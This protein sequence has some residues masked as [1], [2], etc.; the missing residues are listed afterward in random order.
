MGVYHF[1]FLFNFLISIHCCQRKVYKNSQN[2]M[3]LF[4]PHISTISENCSIVS[5]LYISFPISSLCL[6]WINFSQEYRYITSPS[7]SFYSSLW[8][9]SVVTLASP[10]WNP[11]QSTGYRFYKRKQTWKKRIKIRKRPKFSSF[12]SY[13]AIVWLGYDTE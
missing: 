7:V 4:S 1:P 11:S 12:D 2:E 6:Y 5:I 10:S 8:R 13:L 9:Y 3:L